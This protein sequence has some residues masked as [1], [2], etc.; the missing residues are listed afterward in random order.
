MGT[1]KKSESSQPRGGT[2]SYP[3]D[4]LVKGMLSME[5]S[6]KEQCGTAPEG[7][8]HQGGGISEEEVGV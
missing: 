1:R 5:Q 6:S 3:R 8:G 7:L 2:K 4:K